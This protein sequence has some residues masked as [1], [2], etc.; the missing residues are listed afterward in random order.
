MKE[1]G[2]AQILLIIGILVVVVGAVFYI[3]QSRFTQPAPVPPSPKI[4][5]VDGAISSLD[6]NFAELSTF[7]EDLELK[8]LL[9]LEKDL[10][11]ANFSQL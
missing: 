3:Y 1:K 5:T 10:S 2:F 4:E 8:E 7:E 9:E 6:G 11:E